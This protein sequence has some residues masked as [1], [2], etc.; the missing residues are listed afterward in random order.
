M[1]TDLPKTSKT[2]Y[3]CILVVINH[4]TKMSYFIP[5][6]KSLNA[7]QAANLLIDMVIRHHGLPL[8]IV[9]DR[10]KHWINEFW[11][12]LC[13][14]LKIKQAFTTAHRVQ[15]DKQTERMNT[16]LESYLRVYCNQE[17]NNWDQHLA[18]VEFVYNNSRHMATGVIS[19][20]ANQGYHP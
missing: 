10:N 11:K 8:T 17:Q 14:Y 4:F 12:C 1:I 9:L 5:C 2:S 16:I 13:N 6:K 18:S 15:A 20:F 7:E 19:F 3:N